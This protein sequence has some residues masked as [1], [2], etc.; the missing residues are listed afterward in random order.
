MIIFGEP[1]LEKNNI[2]A[3]IHFGS[4]YSRYP[5]V[6]I[7]CDRLDDD[8]SELFGR[9]ARR[10]LLSWLPP[11]GTL[12]L[13]NIHKAPPVVRPLLEREVA[14]A[15]MVA[16]MDFEDIDLEDL[17]AAKAVPQRQ[18]LPRIVMTAEVRVPDLEIHARVIK[19]PPLRVRP[20]DIGDLAAYYLKRLARQ[21]G[22]GPLTLAPA[23]VR[24]LEAGQ[25]PNNIRELQAAVERAV[26]QEALARRGEDA[27]A[28]ISPQAPRVISEEV[29][30]F[31]SQ[32]KDRMRVDLLRALPVVRQFL[33]SD[34][35]PNGINFKFTVYA[36]AAIVGILFIGP[37]DRD[38]NFALNAFWCYWWPLSFIAYPFLGRVWCA[39]CPFMI[40]GELVQGVRKATGAT[41][42][43]WPKEAMDRWGP[44]FLFW[45]FAAILVW[46]EVWDLP[47]SA[48]LSSWLL[49]LITA[50]A[51]VGSFFFERRIWCRCDKKNADADGQLILR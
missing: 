37:Q 26:S 12:I 5:L 45:L 43:K 11:E 14:T 13:N 28:L 2:A 18:Q 7:D 1:G 21:R 20:E 33:R 3:L 51:M 15:S 42:L 48:A 30:W 24:A 4:P 41:L 22:L 23:A 34:V 47:Q 35:W 29:F 46:E 27:D 16:S 17:I 49:L 31:A 8:A 38:H 50:G 40:Y 39:V 36:F 9:G 10:G 32:A 6:S 25:Y 44:W 19:V